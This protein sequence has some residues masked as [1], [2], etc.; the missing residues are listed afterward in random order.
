[1][2]GLVSPLPPLEPPVPPEP[3]VLPEP[4]PP[5]LVLL[6]SEP[7]L[8]AATSAA[9]AKERRIRFIVHVLRAR[10]RT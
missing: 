8:Q 4:E 5:V 7:P 3:P 6:L 2:S 1:M 10:V 9:I